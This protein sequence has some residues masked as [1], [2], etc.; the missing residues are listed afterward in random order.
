VALPLEFVSPSQINAVVPFGIPVNGVQQLL[1][2]Q[3]GAYSLPETVVV[4]AANPAV[5]TLS[6]SGQ[7]SGAIQVVKADGTTFVAGANQP[8]SVGD[9]L[10]IYCTGLGAVSPGV[11]DGA[12]APLGQL[13]YTVN[14]VTV[15]IG[16]QSA[17]VLFAGLTPGYAGLYQVNVIGPGGIGSGPNVPV[18]LSTAGF[19]SPNVTV[20]VQ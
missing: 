7:G 4:A 6:Q 14:P 1:V 8:A 17:Q 19:I 15:T 11:P 12:A 5:F 10:V 16:G 9:A 20:A 3:N 13:S 18:V 2:S